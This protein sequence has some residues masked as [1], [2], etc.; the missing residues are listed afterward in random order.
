DDVPKNGNPRAIF[1][2]FAEPNWVERVT[3]SVGP[4]KADLVGTTDR[5]IQAAVDYVARK[6]GGTVQVLPG[7]YR[8]R[9]S[10]FLQSKVRLL[11]SGTETVLFKE[12]SVATKL[13]VDGDHWDQEVTLA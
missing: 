7:I 1:G 10:V 11:G 5:V 13:S 8:L 6:G 2:D 9:N 3:I 4:E 12:P